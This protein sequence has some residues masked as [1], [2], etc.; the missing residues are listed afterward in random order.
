MEGSVPVPLLPMSV[1]GTPLYSRPLGGAP[2]PPRK[3]PTGPS[4]PVGEVS[5]GFPGSCGERSVWDSG[6]CGRVDSGE[7]RRLHP[8][9]LSHQPSRHLRPVR[10]ECQLR[11]PHHDPHVTGN[12]DPS[13]DG[14]ESRSGKGREIGSGGP[15]AMSVGVGLSTVGP[16]PTAPRPGGV[17]ASLSATVP[18]SS[19][20]DLSPLASTT[21]R[22][23]SGPVA[24][25]EYPVPHPSC[26]HTPSSVSV[27]V[28]NRDNRQRPK[29]PTTNFGPV[30]ASVHGGVHNTTVHVTSDTPCVLPPSPGRTSVHRP[31]VREG[32]SPDT[33]GATEP[34]GVPVP[35]GD[36]K[37]V[38]RPSFASGSESQGLGHRDCVEGVRVPYLCSFL[39]HLLSQSVPETPPP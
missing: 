36:D 14:V 9:Q 32:T 4:S 7:C 23:V 16:R 31:R 10:R 29:V 19:M 33:R 1:R 13:R 34:N 38:D 15:S 35:G 17:P 37:E 26:V 39:R 21:V 12:S 22:E 24:P 25:G 18:A 11:P 27:T 6:S 30:V 28:S 2:D 5:S 20:S 8:A 3:D